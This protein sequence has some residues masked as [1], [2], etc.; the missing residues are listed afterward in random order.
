MKKAIS[1]LV[2]L[3]SVVGVGLGFAWADSGRD[4][5][6]VSGQIVAEGS[7]NLVF[8]DASNECSKNMSM[9]TIKLIP[10][11]IKEYSFTY[12]NQSGVTS[13]YYPSMAISSDNSELEKR[14]D[15]TIMYTK[16]GHDVVVYS[17]SLYDLAIT[18]YGPES[19]LEAD[20]SMRTVKFIFTNNSNQQ[21][22]ATSKLDYVLTFTE[23]VDPI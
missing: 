11:Q 13:R 23:P 12:K 15:I 14:I 22:I 17:G 2:L 21:Y 19:Y 4:E 9:D 18:N 6:N 5:V 1:V 10:N 3:T 16:N 8:C 20:G 7:F